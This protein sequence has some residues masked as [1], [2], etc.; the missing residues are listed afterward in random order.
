MIFS[1]H[2]LARGGITN[3]FIYSCKQVLY[4]TFYMKSTTLCTTQI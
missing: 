3:F 1:S 4:H 2:V